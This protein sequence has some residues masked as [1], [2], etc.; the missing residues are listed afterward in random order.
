MKK[1]ENSWKY[2]LDNF[3]D[4]TN[5]KTP[6]EAV[7]F[8]FILVVCG[9]G[10]SV[11]ITKVLGI[12]AN[13][14]Y[15]EGLFIGVL[16]SAIIAIFVYYKMYNQKSLSLLNHALLV[17]GTIMTLVKGGAVGYI[18]IAI[19]TTLKN[20]ETKSF[21]LNK[22]IKEKIVN[23][24]NNKINKDETIDNSL[25][26]SNEK[27]KDEAIDELKKLKELLELE[28]ISKVEFEEKSRELKKIILDK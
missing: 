22:D 7:V 3:F 5:E 16:V 23:N 4:F 8:Y 24:L 27:S 9:I 6:K 18:F 19:S 12:F 25:D 15:Q 14:G 21:K 10:F 2:V 17:I 11:V 26:K 20:D 28:L 13:L 1:F